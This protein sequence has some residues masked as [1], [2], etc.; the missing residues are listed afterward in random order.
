MEVVLAENMPMV[1]NTARSI[2]QIMFVQMCC[3]K[4]DIKTFVYSCNVPCMLSLISIDPMPSQTLS[5][6]CLKLKHLMIASHGY[7]LSY[8]GPIVKH[9][10]TSTHPR[11]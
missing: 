11:T 7:Y 6:D 10:T 3:T 5:T 8:L 4:E 1:C 9:D 2:A